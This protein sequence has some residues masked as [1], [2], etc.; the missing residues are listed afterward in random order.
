MN[1][2]D[3]VISLFFNES[4]PSRLAVHGFM[5]KYI[6]PTGAGWIRQRD[7]ALAKTVVRL[8]IEDNCYISPIY[9]LQIALNDLVPNGIYHSIVED[10][11]MG[12]ETL[13]CIDE[14]LNRYENDTGILIAEMK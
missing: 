2:R 13:M 12:P 5:E 4:T 14:Y 10:G 6:Y 1:D 7:E 9:R 3:W 11:K 8:S